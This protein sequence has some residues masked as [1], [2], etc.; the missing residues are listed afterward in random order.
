MS[1]DTCILANNF[2]FV[3]DETREKSDQ[4][5]AFGA[6]IKFNEN[7]PTGESRVLESLYFDSDD[8]AVFIMKYD[9]P[10]RNIPN[11]PKRPREATHNP[12][13]RN[14]W[15]IKIGYDMLNRGVF[16]ANVANIKQQIEQNRSDV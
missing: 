9:E 4:D 2:V 15:N 7:L 3:R 10:D 6:I 5:T 14:Y 16:D 12:S 8:T 13:F 1:I 11:D